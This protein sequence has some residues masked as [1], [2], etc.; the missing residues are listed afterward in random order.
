MAK[1]SQIRRCYSCGAVLQSEDPTKEGYVKKETLENAS[2]NFLFC[3]HCFELER[4][5]NKSNDP[6]V[7]EDYL[8]FIMDAKRKN[9][10]IV[11]VVNL[12]SFEASFSLQINAILQG[13]DILVVGNKFDLL[14]ASCTEE[15]TREYVAHRFRASGIKLTRDDVILGSATTDENAKNILSRI[16]ELRN[17]RDVYVIGSSLSGKTTLVQSFLRVYSNMSKGTISTH[18]YP[19]TKL[20]VMEIPL[21]RTASLYDAPG[22]SINNS[23]LFNLDRATLKQIYLT[24]AVESRKVSLEEGQVLCLGGIGYIQLIK[25]KKTDFKCYFHDHVELK[26]LS[27]QRV[28]DKFIQ[29]VLRKRL[30]PSLPKIRSGKDLDVFEIT[31][32]ES[33]YR[34]IGVQGLG[35]VNFKAANQTFRICLPK[36]VAI[37][38]SRPKVLTK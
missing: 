25:G 10:L 8:K 18:L 30:V 29:L 36:G 15:D 11:Y 23:I 28:D 1:I 5:K 13:M 16:Y 21:S 9:A 19:K 38:S 31:I 24:K 20:S 6:E 26:K 33:N 12:F 37:Y 3:D 14:P 27:G 7:S 4:Y 35:W 2:Q 34:D 22:I 32:T 17:G